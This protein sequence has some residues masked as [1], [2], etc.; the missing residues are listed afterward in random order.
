M[1]AGVQARRANKR[2]CY[3]LTLLAVAHGGVQPAPQTFAQRFGDH[4]ALAFK[5]LHYPMR[6]RGNSHA[7]R[8]HLN[9]Q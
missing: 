5:T 1:L 7:R 3:R 4:Q 8:Y 2:L 9:Q 6:Q